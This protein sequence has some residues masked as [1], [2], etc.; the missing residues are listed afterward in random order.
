ML[1]CDLHVS[2]HYI[3]LT[4]KKYFVFALSGDAPRSA[5]NA[6]WPKLWAF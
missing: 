3:E 2:V 4:G 6:A 1:F 5:I